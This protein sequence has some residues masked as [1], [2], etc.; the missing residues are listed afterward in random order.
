MCGHCGG[1]G[2]LGRAATDRQAVPPAE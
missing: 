1:G 2:H